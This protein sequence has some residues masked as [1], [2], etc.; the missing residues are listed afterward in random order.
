MENIESPVSEHLQQI[1]DKVDRIADEVLD[2][3]ARMSGLV[4]NLEAIQ[5]QHVDLLRAVF[6][7]A[8]ALTQYVEVSQK[9]Y[10]DTAASLLAQNQVLE[11]NYKQ[12]AE[13]SSVLIAQSKYLGQQGEVIGKIIARIEA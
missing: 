8:Q 10:A 13:I 11:A 9:Q 3:K 1:R 6:A 12:Q 2:L 4:S 7:Q 5:K